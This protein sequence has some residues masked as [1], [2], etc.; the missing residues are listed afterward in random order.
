MD[1]L[2]ENGP[3]RFANACD[4]CFRWKGLLY[5]QIYF[6]KFKNVFPSRNRWSSRL[7]AF[8]VK[9]RIP[10]PSA[11]CLMMTKRTIIPNTI[12]I[13]SVVLYDN[14]HTRD[15]DHIRWY[16][17]RWDHYYIVVSLFLLPC[18]WRRPINELPRPPPYPLLRVSAGKL[19]LVNRRFGLWSGS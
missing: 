3:R 10:S 11:K 7:F 17:K 13:L 16:R 15:V 2:R 18:T 9:V 4:E 1:S 6:R 19:W 12:W 8:I 5:W 14:L